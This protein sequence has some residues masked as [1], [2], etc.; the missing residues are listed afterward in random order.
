MSSNEAGTENLNA[1]GRAEQLVS[2]LTDLSAC[3]SIKDLTLMSD[4]ALLAVTTRLEQAS[5]KLEAILVLAEGT[6]SDRCLGVPRDS[7]AGREGCRDAVDLLQRVSRL[8]A[9]VLRQRVLLADVTRPMWGYSAGEIP[10]KYEAVAAAFFAGDL[11]METAQL[12]IKTLSAVPTWVDPGRVLHAEQCIV[13]QAAGYSEAYGIAGEGWGSEAAA[14][15]TEARLPVTY[16]TMLRVCEVW[17]NSLDQDGPEPDDEAHMSHRFFKIGRVRKGLVSVSGSLLP[18]VATLLGNMITS[19][20]S[21]KTDTNTVDP[22]ERAAAFGGVLGSCD[23]ELGSAVASSAEVNLT[24]VGLAQLGLVGAGAGSEAEGE[25]PGLPRAESAGGPRSGVRFTESDEPPAD[26]RS[27][28]QKMHDALMVI[29]QIAGKASEMPSMGGAPVTVLIQTTQADL[30]ASLERDLSRSGRETEGWPGTSATTVASAWSAENSRAVGS[31]GA[32]SEIDPAW[33]HGQ[34]GTPVPVSFAAVR[35]GICSGA[36]QRVIVGERGRI[37]GIESPTRIFTPHQRR[38][39]SARDGGCVIPGCTVPS[40]WCEVH[41]VTEWARG[42]PTTTENGVL[43][44]WWHHRSIEVSGWHVRMVEGIPEVQAPKWLDPD[45]RWRSVQPLLKV[46]RTQSAA[47]PSSSSSLSQQQVQQQTQQQTQQQLKQQLQPQ[48]QPP[49][50]PP[51][52][53]PQRQQQ[54]RKVRTLA[55]NRPGAGD[56]SSPSKRV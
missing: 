42:G 41:H 34:D 38:A 9:R 16:D 8:P 18:E 29:A 4:E 55:P 30:A 35:H 26:M 39:I 10:A 37:L 46:V 51:Q 33:L 24:G 31:V 40:T 13:N 50:T 32:S 52:T 12:I 43:L 11:P 49:Q 47:R 28:G 17:R 3:M 53:P 1:D 56:W 2:G 54:Q 20:N 27:S 15:D 21:P 6:V 44:C 23:P 5:R 7:L 22:T 19:V 36:T 25:R 14:R 45:R 48:L